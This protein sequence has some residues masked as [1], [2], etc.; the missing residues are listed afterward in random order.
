MERIPPQIQEC[1]RR[2]MELGISQ[3]RLAHEAGVSKPLIEMLERGFHR[4]PT[5]TTLTKIET[6]LARLE[7][8][9]AAAALPPAE[10]MQKAV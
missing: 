2:R 10:P 5:L 9:R 4:N 1:R 3:K 8:E 6:A 7:A